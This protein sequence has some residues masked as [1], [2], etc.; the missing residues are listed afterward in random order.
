MST[1]LVCEPPRSHF[2][3]RFIPIVWC[4]SA[5]ISCRKTFSVS[6]KATTRQK[7]PD[8]NHAVYL[9]LVNDCQMR[10]ICKI[11]GIS[12][13]LLYDKIDF[14]DR[15][16]RLV[17]S[18]HEAKLASGEVSLKRA[19]LS[20][21]RQEYTFNWGTQHDR[22]NV[23]LRSI[24]TA[25]NDTGYV[26]GMN[27]DFDSTLDPGDI[28]LQARECHDYDIDQPHRKFAR[29]WLEEDRRQAFVAQSERAETDVNVE[30]K[31]PSGGMQNT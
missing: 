25:E 21:D 23:V 11:V 31:A 5:W 19:Y 16:C 18:A 27:L 22:R 4:Y 26:F 8:V 17:A 12:P 28:E 15:Q 7:R 2:N 13:Q 14:L 6:S 1:Q 10:R 3:K 9:H 30:W 24:A 29:L 20:V